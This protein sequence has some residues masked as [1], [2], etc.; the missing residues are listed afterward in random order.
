MWMTPHHREPT[1]LRVVEEYIGLRGQPRICLADD[2]GR[3]WH[4][5]QTEVRQTGWGG[6][7]KLTNVDPEWE[8]MIRRSFLPRRPRS[9]AE[10]KRVRGSR[11]VPRREV[12]SQA[13]GAAP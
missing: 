7:F 4:Y 5:D 3:V 6:T 2:L 1:P 9:V 13:M 10:M 11:R 12:R 8:R